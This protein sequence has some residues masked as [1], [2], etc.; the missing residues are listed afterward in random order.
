MAITISIAVQGQLDYLMLFCRSIEQHTTV[1][2]EISIWNNE[3]DSDIRNFCSTKNYTYFESKENVGVTKSL[4]AMVENAKYDFV[5]LAD[6]DYYALP[7]WDNIILDAPEVFW[8]RPTLIDPREYMAV[9]SVY[10]QYGNNIKRF[11]EKGLLDDFSNASFPEILGTHMPP[12][13][14]KQDYIN[15]GGYNE[16]FY[17]GETDFLWR[18]FCYYKEHGFEQTVAANSFIYHFGSKTERSLEVRKDNTIHQQFL[19]D[20]YQMDEAAIGAAMG[21]F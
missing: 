17:V 11:N 14:R 15:F 1:P 16:S 7:N 12:V 9:R 10:G 13:M 20:T 2:Y 3:A 4:N 21:I 5:F 18:A 8:K 6:S 19:I